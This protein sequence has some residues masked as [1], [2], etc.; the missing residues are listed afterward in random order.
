MLMLTFA[1]TPHAPFERV[2]PGEG[3]STYLFEKIKLAFPL[4]DIPCKMRYWYV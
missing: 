3:L 1:S 4:T 2:I